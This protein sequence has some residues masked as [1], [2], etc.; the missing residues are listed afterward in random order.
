MNRG[1]VLSVTSVLVNVAR[2]LL[3]GGLAILMCLGLCGVLLPE[4]MSPVLDSSAL[5]LH[6]LG[7]SISVP[8]KGLELPAVRPLFGIVFAMSL[9]GLILAIIIG[10]NLMGILR[11]ASC[12]TPFATENASRVRGMGFAILGWA[13]LRISIQAAFGTF[14]L[15]HLAWPGVDLSVKVNLAGETILFGLLVLILAEVFRYGVGL[16][17]QH[18]PTV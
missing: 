6:D 14:L 5:E 13:A 11:T 10:N 15:N 4:R 17:D 3:S 7:L 2:Y 9:A 1:S 8:L 18:D 16:Q 12:G